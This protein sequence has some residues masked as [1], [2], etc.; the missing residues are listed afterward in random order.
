MRL[1]FLGLGVLLLNV[2]WGCSALDRLNN[3]LETPDA[4]PAE[5]T[6]K[7]YQEMLEQLQVDYI[8]LRDQVQVLESQLE[9]QTQARL[10]L[11]E[12]I[13]KSEKQWQTNFELM[14]RSVEENLK[15]TQDQITE[16]TKHPKEEKI[17]TPNYSS[18]RD[19]SN[20]PVK[21]TPNEATSSPG[22]IEDYSL[23]SQPK[24]QTS[25]NA[26]IPPPLLSPRS[27]S[28]S[29]SAKQEVAAPRPL[30]PPPQNDVLD[31]TKTKAAPNP[32]PEETDAPVAVASLVTEEMP[33]E[34]DDPVLNESS[35]PRVL[36][37]N[38]GVKRLYNQGMSALIQRN[39]VDAIQSFKNFTK[40]FPDDFD[41]D[42]AYYWIGYSY[43]KLN[44]TKQ[45]GEAF[46]EILK[47]YEHRPTSQGYKTPDAIYM[48]GK[49]AEQDNLTEQ[50]QYYYRQ[51]IERFPDSTSG[52]NAS[53]DLKILLGTP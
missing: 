19:S 6:S 3:K 34:F 53:K 46:R 26:S 21:T 27:V 47:H 25:A 38:P 13:E 33:G 7:H 22:L 28:R 12:Q 2:L 23:F 36:K 44:Q 50:A 42:N 48:L 52:K 24:G 43:Y 49:L 29:A 8:Q 31:E 16:I 11:Q 9:E 41:S 40:Q 15:G 30:P 37:R 39:Y 51:V 32:P 4:T 1:F 20:K 17:P 18:S 14:E 10:A 45:A 5:S 35:S